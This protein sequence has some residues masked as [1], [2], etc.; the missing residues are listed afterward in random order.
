MDGPRLSQRGHAVSRIVPII[1][2]GTVTVLG[3]VV[4]YQLVA[5]VTPLD[6]ETAIAVAPLHVRAIRLAERYTPPPVEQFDAVSSRTIFDPARMPA[7]EPTMTGN[8]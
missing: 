4:A 1:L 3:L 5:P 6:E 7:V 2:A 8:A